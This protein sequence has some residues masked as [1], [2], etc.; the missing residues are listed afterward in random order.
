MIPQPSYIHNQSFIKQWTNLPCSISLSWITGKDQEQ[1]SIGDAIMRHGWVKS[2]T[3]GGG[4]RMEAGVGCQGEVAE[5]SV[6]GFRGAI[7]SFPAR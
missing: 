2:G 1:A 3:G 7:D 6:V 4:A 5:G